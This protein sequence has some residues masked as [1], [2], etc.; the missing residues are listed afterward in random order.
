VQ[1]LL[2]I[3]G[4]TSLETLPSAGPSGGDFCASP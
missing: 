1:F 4:T 3:D 2:S